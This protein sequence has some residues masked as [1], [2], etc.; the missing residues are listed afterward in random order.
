METPL[1]DDT[2]HR[3]PSIGTMPHRAKQ[4][5]I[6]RQIDLLVFWPWHLV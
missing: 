6:S 4:Q 3:P 5:V 2:D 1:I